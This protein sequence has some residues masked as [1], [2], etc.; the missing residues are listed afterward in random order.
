MRI[1]RNARGTWKYCFAIRGRCERT[2]FSWCSRAYPF[3]A[4]KKIGKTLKIINFLHPG[5]NYLFS[6]SPLLIVS[7]APPPL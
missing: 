4:Y 2:I 3:I 6:R 7:F 5:H 1:R